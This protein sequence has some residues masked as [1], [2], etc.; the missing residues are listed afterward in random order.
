MQLINKKLDKIQLIFAKNDSGSNDVSVFDLK[1]LYQAVNS[2]RIVEKRGHKLFLSLVGD[3]LVE[4]N[5]IS[6]DTVAT[7]N[8]Q[9][10]S[11]AISLAKKGCGV[12]PSFILCSRVRV[13]LIRIWAVTFLDYH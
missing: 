6:R 11:E 13:N 12:S 7:V 5:K 1:S 2:S 4:V 10:I 8:R 9:T 3:S